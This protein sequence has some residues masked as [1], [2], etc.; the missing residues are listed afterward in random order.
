MK[1]KTT[2]KK[3]IAYYIV[4]AVSVALLITAIALTVYF[5]T[6][7]NDNVLDNPNGPSID[8]PNNPGSD[9]P[10][11][12]NPDNPNPDKPNPDK[13]T[14]GDDTVKF[15]N[16]LSVVSVQTNAD[17]YHNQTLGWYYFHD[18]VDI[19]AENGADV[20]A[21]AAGTVVSVV[22]DETLVTEIVIDHGNGLHTVYCMVEAVAGLKKGDTVKSG[23]KIATVVEGKGMEYK[24]GAH[25][26]LEVKVNGEQKDPVQ[27]LTLSDK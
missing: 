6:G 1:E 5:V 20:F 2:G 3:R 19:A 15:T 24:D 7:A 9:K 26:H 14:G 18:G 8:N 25:L 23:Q 16:P 27:Y 12:P 17:F 11:N 4:L 21:M 13:P 22:A 10:D